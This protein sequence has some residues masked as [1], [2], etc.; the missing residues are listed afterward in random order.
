M[1][2][3]RVCILLIRVL[4]REVQAVPWVQMVA[5]EAPVGRYYKGRTHCSVETAERRG[6][7]PGHRQVQGCR[8]T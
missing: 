8:D 2:D 1:F 6:S 7:N 4:W 5:R 3:Q